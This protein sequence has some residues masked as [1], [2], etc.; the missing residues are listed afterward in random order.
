M[1]KKVK[2][3]RPANDHGQATSTSHFNYNPRAPAWQ[4]FDLLVRHMGWAR[5][6]AT[7]RD[8]RTD[9]RRALVM[10][11]N[12]RFGTDEQKLEAWQNICEILGIQPLPES[13]T[14]CRQAIKKVKVNICDLL[15]CLRAGDEAEELRTFRTVKQLQKYSTANKK[16]F[17][18]D[19]AK[20]GGLLRH[21][22]R[23][24]YPHKQA[25]DDT[26]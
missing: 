26:T 3:K 16:I 8:A 9:F 22:L 10:D 20:A 18:K 6:S 11:F 17:P 4:E 25:T 1:P 5:R 19:E 2:S 14:K 13:I 24:F 23:L 12:F 15:D 7:Y 21:L